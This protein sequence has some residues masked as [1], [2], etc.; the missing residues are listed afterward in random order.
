MLCSCTA[1]L[2]N[3]LASGSDNPSTT[4][5][6]LTRIFATQLSKDTDVPAFAIAVGSCKSIDIQIGGLRKVGGEE[7][8]GSSARFNIGSNAKSM[9]ATVAARL[10]DRGV[11]SLDST[12]EEIWP[13]AGKKYPDKADITLTQLFSHSGGLPAFDKGSELDQVPKFQG[14]KPEIRRAAAEWFLMQPLESN[15]GGTTLYSNAGYVIAGYLLEQAAEASL[16]T[17]LEEEVFKPLALDASLGEP[18]NMPGAQPWGHYVSG[19]VVI[20]Y[21]EADPPIPTFLEAAGNVSLS[22]LAYARYLQAQLCALIGESDFIA[23][24]TARRLHRPIKEG[25]SA[26]GWGGTEL[27][28]APVSFHVGGTGDFT[29]YAALSGQLDRSAFAILNVGGAPAQQ[30]LQWLIEVMSLPDNGSEY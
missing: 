11:L 6:D 20:A 2:A 15:P 29:A 10:H 5:E 1:T 8:I 3:D 13:E 24:D 16:E 23:P 25:G 28:G 7:P 12:V 17:L 22:P 27:N 30:A 4:P 26:L 9:L 21:E 19:D 14:A 18:R